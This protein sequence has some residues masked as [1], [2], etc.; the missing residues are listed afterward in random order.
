MKYDTAQPYIASYI[1]LRKAGKIAFLLRSKT[2]WMNGRYG[3]PS[4]K[5][6]AKEEVGIDVQAE[7]LK[8]VL[9]VHRKE[10]TDRDMTWVDTYFEAQKW[11]GEVTNNEPHKHSE[12][13]WFN[14]DDL[15][16]NIIPSVK[17]A[18]QE[19]AAGKTYSEYGWVKAS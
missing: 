13:A 1:I 7:D 8:P 10:P 16:D 9:I 4:G 19:I 12:L 17:S 11:A 6:E 15:P 3:L 14:L 5:I 18:L 2:T